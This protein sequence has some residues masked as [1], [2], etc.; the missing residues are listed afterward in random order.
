MPEPAVSKTGKTFQAI[1]RAA[2]ELFRERGY[3]AVSMREIAQKAGYSHTTIYMH[4]KDKEALL[5]HLSVGPLSKLRREMES[6]L[7]DESRPPAARLKAV[8]REFIEF[9]L[10]HRNMYQ[11]FFMARAGRVDAAE[12]TS[13]VHRLRNE[14]F[15]LLQ[16]GVQ[17]V[18]QLGRDDHETLLAYSRIYFYALHGIV[19][20]Y[21]NSQETPDM[22]TG[23]LGTTFD[24]ALDV[25]LTGIRGTLREHTGKGAADDEG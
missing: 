17:M 5:H 24:L 19:A 3:D 8:S 7:A 14:L 12:P 2:G 4:F 16:D 10:E 21:A 15:R 6:V 1:L 13:R 25:I 20:T 9:C 23:R 22:L 18:L 11:I